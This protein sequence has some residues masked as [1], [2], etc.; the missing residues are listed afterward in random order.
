MIIGVTGGQVV[1]AFQRMSGQYSYQVDSKMM[2]S[3]N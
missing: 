3:A 1:S 2:L